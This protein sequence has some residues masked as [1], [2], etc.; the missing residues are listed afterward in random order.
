MSR[1]CIMTILSI[2]IFVCGFKIVKCITAP[3]ISMSEEHIQAMYP[4]PI[5]RFAYHAMLLRQVG[6][7]KSKAEDIL[8][9]VTNPQLKKLYLVVI[10][11]AYKQPIAEC[12][13]DKQLAARIF[14][15]VMEIVCTEVDQEQRNKKEGTQ[16]E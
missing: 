15:D 2:I 14:G 4:R 7:T 12:I 16:N 3:S 13:T 5:S 8:V 11:E 6:V 10:R 1:L 9:V